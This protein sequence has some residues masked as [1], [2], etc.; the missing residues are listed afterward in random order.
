MENTVPAV[1]RGAGSIEKRGCLFV[2]STE[3]SHGSETS[4]QPERTS[5]TWGKMGETSQQ[6]SDMS[7]TDA[8]RGLLLTLI[9]VTQPSNNQFWIRKKERVRV[10]SR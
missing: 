4:H 9:P 6:D 7:V 8:L 1:K 10:V 5:R 3:E 2:N